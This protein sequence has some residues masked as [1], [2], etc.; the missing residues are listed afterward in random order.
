MMNTKKSYKVTI[1][2]DQYT[3]VS[4]ESETHIVQAA[5]AVDALMKEIA[6]K[7]KV[8]D[9]KKYAIFAA[10]QLASKLIN[11][12]SEV[13]TNNLAKE[14]LLCKLEKDLLTL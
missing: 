2:G 3:L 14:K 12:E 6:D 7:S 9:S 5:A 10:L 4:D 1:F 8:S 13:R 11:L